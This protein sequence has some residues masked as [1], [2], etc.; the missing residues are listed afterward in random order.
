MF[1]L[2]FSFMF[3]LKDYSNVQINSDLYWHV[4]SFKT[5][6]DISWPEIIYRFI[7]IPHSN[8]PLFWAYVKLVSIFTN[9]AGFFVF[10]HYFLTFILIA[11]LGKIVNKNKFVIIILC[12]LFAHFGVL[13]NVYQVWRHTFAFLLFMIGVFS[14]DVKSKNLRPRIFI[15][16]SVF[17]HLSTAIVI[18]FFELFT[19]LTKRSRK[20][21][22]SKLYSK[23]IIGY[24]VIVVV[25][26]ILIT[27]FG[28]FFG[29][30]FRINDTLM[31]YYQTF[32]PTGIGYNSLFNS[33]SILICMFLWLR[34]KELIKADIFIATQYFIFIILLIV[35]KVPDV[36]SRYTYYVMLGGSI[37]IGKMVTGNLRFGFNL[38]IILFIYDIYLISYSAQ[39]ME[40]LSVRF[41]SEYNNPAYGLG[42]MILNYNDLLN[43][44]I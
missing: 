3:F 29:Q 40:P 6:D 44:N 13:S 22:I 7:S 41:H 43:F 36:Y 24:V 32:L 20:F 38:L 15:Y 10:F 5:I 23:E 21:E 39:V 16:S 1:A 26:F 35:L 37:L 18:V 12:V 9:S 42:A 33:F 4:I 11:Y 25:V 8:E 14:F 2:S 28:L 27:K 19:F 17:F 34:R 31:I 30:I